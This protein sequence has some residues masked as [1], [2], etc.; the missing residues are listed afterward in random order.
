[1]RTATPIVYA[2]VVGLLLACSDTTGPGYQ[3]L[4]GPPSPGGSF[5]VSPS[6]VTIQYG[7]TFKLTTRYTGNPA[8]LAKPSAIA[9]TSSDAN[10]AT[11]SAG[12][13]RGVSG[14]ETRIV[15]TWAG[16]QA[17]ALVTVVVPTKTH[18]PP[19]CAEQ[20]LRSRC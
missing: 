20:K 15:A 13:V 3:P 6:A 9:W 4:P 16:Y 18:E 12:L 7:Q 1:M 19:T 11:V 17:S 8:L 2:S 14:G 5:L 10:V